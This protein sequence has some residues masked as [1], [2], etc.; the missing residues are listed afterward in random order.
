MVARLTVGKKKYAEVEA[1]MKRT[2]DAADTLRLKLL[3]AVDEDSAAYAV[4]MAAQKLDKADSGRDAAIQAAMQGAIDSPLRVMQLALDSMAVI[5]TAADLGNSNA[6]TD[7]AVGG[8]LA[9]AA[10][11]GAA[12]NVHVNLP[13]LKDV[14]LA[15]TIRCNADKLL[16]EARALHG[17]ILAIAHTRAG[18]S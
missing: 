8:H 1:E 14:E 9:L 18:L 13:G 7:A 16:G 3:S 10:V 4:V 12:L 5:R 2:I 17:E 11:E 15:A 6:V